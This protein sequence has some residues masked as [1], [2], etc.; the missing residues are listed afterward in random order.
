MVRCYPET[1]IFYKPLII[2]QKIKT[3]M[4]HSFKFIH[5]Y[6]RDVVI[7]ITAVNLETAKTLLKCVAQFPENFN[8]EIPFINC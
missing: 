5:A 8:V 2:N 7:T 4:K 1:P 3:V 6:D